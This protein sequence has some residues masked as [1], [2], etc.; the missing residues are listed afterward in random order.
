M[1]WFAALSAEKKQVVLCQLA[2]MFQQA[3]ATVH[4]VNGAIALSGLKASFT[5][6]VLMARGRVS[7][8]A[9][10]V[11]SLPGYEWEKAFRLFLALLAIS[12]ARRR[13][14][15]CKGVCNHWWH[16]DLSDGEAVVRR[17]M[18]LSEQ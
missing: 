17:V 1:W 8:Q 6:C 3:G 13:R 14:L 4:E 5:P 9:A 12:D 16:Q 15:V 10:K 18:G 2:S 11:I 7:I